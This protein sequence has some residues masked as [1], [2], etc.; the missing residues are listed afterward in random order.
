MLLSKTFNPP[1][2][3]FKSTVVVPAKPKA[4]AVDSTQPFFQPQHTDQLTSS[5]AT[6][7]Q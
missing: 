6:V 2:L 1:E 5:L 3:V 4:G 7:S